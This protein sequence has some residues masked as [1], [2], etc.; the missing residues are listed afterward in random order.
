MLDNHAGCLCQSPL[1]G[2]ISER[3]SRRAL[4]SC[5]AGASIAGIA[6]L[7]VAAR[8]AK[9]PRRPILLTNASIFDGQTLPL[10]QGRSVLIENNTIRALP[11]SY[12]KVEDAE[13]IDCNGHVIMPGLIDAHWHSIMVAISP[14]VA[15]SA[16]LSYIYLVAAR[17]AERTLM[18]GFTTVRDL[19]GPA[20]A[21]KR[22]IDQGITVGPRIYPSGAMISQTGGHGDFRTLHEVFGNGGSCLGASETAGVGAI[23]DGVPN[24]LRRVREQLLQGASQ[25]KI[26]VGGGVSSHYD[27]IDTI[28][29]TKPEI[30]AAV[31]AA[32]DWGTYVCSHVYTSA[33]ILRAI[34]CGVKS[35]EH[36]QLADEETVRRIADTGTWWSLQP[37]LMDEDANVKINP[38]QIADQRT[39]SEGTVHA[40]EMA[41][42]HKVNVAWGTDILFSAEKAATQGKQLAKI[43]RWFD[44]A[45]VLRMA[46]GRNASLL[47]LSGPRNPYPGRIG[48]IEPGALADLIVIKGDP[49]SD[50]DLVADPER[51]MALIM[52]DGVI[53]KNT[54]RP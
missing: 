42:K 2:A 23:A 29:Y 28:Q 13:L 54:M 9:A 40:Y 43:S 27:P 31:D 34:E 17:A 51:T 45:D 12:A 7:P 16:D 21:L 53:Y 41:S 47:A 3:L 18:R 25:V 46:T 32:T 8:A 36:G 15:L 6:G 37:F 33:G 24:V 11:E 39:V 26:M 48:L 35:I 19:G 5:A 22:A 49:T 30:R 44:P 20:F 52:K 10:L 4:L 1:A 14:L 38:Q 50:I